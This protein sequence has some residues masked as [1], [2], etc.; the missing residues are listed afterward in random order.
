MKEHEIG[1]TYKDGD[2]ICLEGEEG[3]HMYVIQS[4]KV[5]VTKKVP[6]G[7]LSLTT[8]KEGEIFGEM[9]LFDHLPRSATIRSVGE[10]VVL[11]VDKKGFFAKVSKDPSLALNILECM[12]KR[13]R[14]LNNELLKLKKRREETLGAFMDL[15]E[16]C[17]LILE[18]VKHS[19]RAENGSIMLLDDEKK[20]LKIAAAFGNEATKKTELKLG[21]GIAGDVV[22][23]GKLELVNN[24]TADQ[25]YEQGEMKVITLLCAPL[26]SRVKIFGVI[27]LSNSQHNFFNLDDL[28]LLRVLSIY[29]SIAIENAQLFITSQ[30]LSDSI[31]RHATLL[32]M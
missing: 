31:I 5:L 8:L 30:N 12:S 11:S 29:A 6:D 32:D 18:E 22:R 20:V 9:A 24:T 7:E 10:S 3:K 4:G 27:N 16:T 1:K 25:R 28:K 26:K 21:K 17:R 23:S 13:I 2:T 19:I 15:E 14:G